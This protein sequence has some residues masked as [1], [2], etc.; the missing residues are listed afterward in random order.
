V[1]A[2]VIHLDRAGGSGAVTAAELAAACPKPFRG[3]ALVLNALGTRQ[4][5]A[6]DEYSVWL[7]RD[8]RRW[9]IERN[10]HLLV[11]DIL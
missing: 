2:T 9:I 11:A 1:E 5:D 3:Q 10:I 4:F 8:A 7:G 6:I